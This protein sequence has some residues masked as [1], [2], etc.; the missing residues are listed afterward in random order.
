MNHNSILGD[1]M[2]MAERELSAF[3]VAVTELFGAEQA[4]ESA[5]HWLLELGIVQPIVPL[6]RPSL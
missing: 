6:T 5:D 2:K 1:L 3:M 4:P